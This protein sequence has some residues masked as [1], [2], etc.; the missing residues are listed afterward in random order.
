M[1]VLIERIELDLKIINFIERR[2]IT[3]V[4]YKL[5]TEFNEKEKR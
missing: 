1:N 4:A 5:Q 3:N 2:I